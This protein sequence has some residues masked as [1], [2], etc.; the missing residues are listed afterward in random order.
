MNQQFEFAQEKFGNNGKRIPS[1]TFF[2]R[3]YTIRRAMLRYCTD[4]SMYTP[5]YELWNL[6]TQI[7]PRLCEKALRMAYQNSKHVNIEE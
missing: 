4:D 7:N 1:K 6:F 5:L 3:A 2:T